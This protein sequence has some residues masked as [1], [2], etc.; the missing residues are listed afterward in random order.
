VPGSCGAEVAG[1]GQN[2]VLT[3]DESAK[4]MKICSVVHS[5][6]FSGCNRTKERETAY[7]NC[8]LDVGTCN[9]ADISV[10]L[11]PSLEEFADN[12]ELIHEGIG[13]W[14]EGVEQCKEKCP[15]GQTFQECGD[16]C[17]ASCA[18]INSAGVDC[19]QTC[20]EGCNCPK[21]ETR[22]SKG[23]CILISDCPSE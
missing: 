14:R 4:A 20:V 16:P 2:P 3:A 12:C 1:S 7:K 18:K 9:H 11:C 17:S 10:C 6:V 19:M 15:T 13:S 21:G 22:D 8:L 23:N 5:E